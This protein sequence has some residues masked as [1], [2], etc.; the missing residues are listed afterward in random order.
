MC[1]DK[2]LAFYS[3][4]CSI[5]LKKSSS[6]PTSK[7][8]C[9]CCQMPSQRLSWSSSDLLSYVVSKSPSQILRLLSLSGRAAQQQCSVLESISDLVSLSFAMAAY[10]SARLISSEMYTFIIIVCFCFRVSYPKTL[11]V[12]L[13]TS[14]ELNQL[15]RSFL[16]DS[17]QAK[18][19]KAVV[20]ICY[21]DSKSWKRPL[22]R[23]P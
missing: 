5:L 14:P 19:I 20:S 4:A 1:S 16:S 21:V 6:K 3:T 2:F 18:P 13:V 11:P 23:I 12:E 15:S 9:L 22:S 17:P 10:L 7:S 8:R